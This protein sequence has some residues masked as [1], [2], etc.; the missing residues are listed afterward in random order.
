MLKNESKI[1][2]YL[3]KNYHLHTRFPSG[4]WLLYKKYTS[5]RDYISEENKPIMTNE[6]HTEEDLLKF[7][8]KHRKYDIRNCSGII[9]LALIYIST[10]FSVLN[11]A[12]FNFKWWSYFHIGF[13]L[14]IGVV[15]IVSTILDIH[16]LDVEYLEINEESKRLEK[17]FSERMKNNDKTQ[18]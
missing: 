10:I 11:F 1:R 7:A 15:F 17:E 9:S 12:I 2:K 4:E 14:G 3:G 13:C 6:T 16:N 18:E 5:W 8:K